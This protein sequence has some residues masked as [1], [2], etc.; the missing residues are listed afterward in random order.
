[1]KQHLNFKMSLPDSSF[2][3]YLRKIY[4]ESKGLIVILEVENRGKGAAM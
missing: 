1:M 4:E 2:S 3:L